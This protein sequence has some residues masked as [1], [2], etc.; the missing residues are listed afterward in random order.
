MIILDAMEVANY[1]LKKQE[2]SS[3]RQRITNLKVQ[4]LCY[5]A[6]GFALAKLGRPLFFDDI[7]K[8]T[9]GPVVN[10]LYGEYKKYGYSSLPIPDEEVDMN[11]FSPEV[12]HVLDT[13]NAVYGVFSATQLRDMTHMES[14]WLQTQIGAPITHQEMKA[15]FEPLVQ[16]AL[17]EGTDELQG[18]ALI[19]AMMNCPELAEED[20]KAR[21]GAATGGY[22]PL[23]TVRR[24]VGDV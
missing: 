8:W 17:D 20:K 1:F 6:Q 13:V 15:Y 21:F 10:S 3:S 24:F 11:R 7:E 9:F 18:Q 16:G 4:K 19:E 2:E 22:K 14:P 5:Y 23:S 12:C